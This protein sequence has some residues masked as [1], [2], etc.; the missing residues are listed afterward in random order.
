[1]D[2]FHCCFLLTLL[3]KR[4]QQCISSEAWGLQTF[5]TTISINHV[6]LSRGIPSRIS[7]LFFK[8]WSKFELLVSM[9]F[10]VF[11]GLLFF[12]FI[13]CKHGWLKKS[14]KSWKRGKGEAGQKVQ[15]QGRNMGK[16]QIKNRLFLQ[17]GFS[18]ET[19]VGGQ[20]LRGGFI[21]SGNSG[22]MTNRDKTI[23]K[24]RGNALI[25]CLGYHCSR[26]QWR[27][28]QLNRWRLRWCVRRWDNGRRSLRR[29]RRGSP[30]LHRRL[31]QVQCSEMRLCRRTKSLGISKL[32]VESDLWNPKT[33]IWTTTVFNW[34]GI[35]QLD[36]ADKHLGTHLIRL[37]NLPFRHTCAASRCTLFR[38]HTIAHTRHRNWNVFSKTFTVIPWSYFAGGHVGS[39][40]LSTSAAGLTVV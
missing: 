21:F 14:V 39:A 4:R 6:P 11:L 25:A 12:D 34:L 33:V 29:S 23:N 10:E 35:H 19:E 2:S 20:Y 24:K 32:E 27:V 26:V 40:S 9:L 28:L 38:C 7:S 31:R 8:Y 13:F 3:Q 37:G 5:V 30:G 18:M 1:M 22:S 16:E 15:I 17:L 36:D